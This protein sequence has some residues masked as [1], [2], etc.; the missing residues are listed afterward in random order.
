V[1][2]LKKVAVTGGLS[3]GKSSV[4]QFFK[5]FGASVV[6]ADEIV[7]RLLTP[8]TK[9]G[10]N[11]IRL[12]GNDVLINNQID[13][14]KIAEKVFNQ[15]SLLDSLEK[16]LHPAVQEEIEHF[17]DEAVKSGQTKLFVAEVPLLFEAGSDRFYDAVIAVIADIET[18][19]ER[20]I[21]ATHKDAQEFKK[22]SSRQLSLDEK[23]QKA[24][25]VIV[26]DGSLEDLEVKTKNLMNILTK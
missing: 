24:D 20:F 9:S 21:R 7:H 1:L 8:E 16:I 23:A 11:V 19:K 4:C 12:I 2:T 22:R 26:N 14:S 6:S 25:Y 3:C 10:Q 17:Y 5:K 18:S 15:P 13:R